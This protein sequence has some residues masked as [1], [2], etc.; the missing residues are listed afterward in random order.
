MK[1]AL[2]P[3]C[4]ASSNPSKIIEPKLA[5]KNKFLLSWKITKQWVASVYEE[6]ISLNKFDGLLMK[7]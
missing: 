3:H 6:S 7:L 1:K 5:Q 4:L 2:G